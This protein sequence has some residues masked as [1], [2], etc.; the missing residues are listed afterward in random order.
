MKLSNL[1]NIK[2]KSIKIDNADRSYADY[3]YNLPDDKPKKQVWAVVGTVAAAI[4]IVLAVSLWA[5]IGRGVRGTDA[6]TPI[7]PADENV[8]VTEE[9]QAQFE[10]MFGKYS[11]HS[12][13]SFERGVLPSKEAL[14]EFLDHEQ[15]P[16]LS[17]FKLTAEEFNAFVFDWFGTEPGYEVNIEYDL[18]K[19]ITVDYFPP[20]LL[21]F[22]RSF[23]DDGTKIVTLTYGDIDNWVVTLS[24]V[25]ISDFE[26]DYFIENTTLN[27][28]F[29]H[30]TDKENMRVS[31]YKVSG[32]LATQI[33]D[34]KRYLKH[35]ETNCK[36]IPDYRVYDGTLRYD[37]M[38]DG[39]MPHT[40]RYDAHTCQLTQDEQS[41]FK[42]LFEKCETDENFVETK[43]L[44]YI[45]SATEVTVTVPEGHKEYKSGTYTIKGDDAKALI[46]ALET[47]SYTGLN[48]LEAAGMI[49][50]KINERTYYLYI[51]DDKIHIENACGGI[52][53]DPD[54]EIIKIMEKYIEKSEI[55]DGTI[56]ETGR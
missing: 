8:E 34:A 38:L 49:E 12:F 23:V 56:I 4:L 51:G 32:E 5:I 21:S 30:K 1:K 14:L 7:I 13:P 18:G 41:R 25:P 39:V 36:C 42:E 9:M 47:K 10:A 50:L 45:P 54:D 48:G 44:E 11:L 15:S 24:Y 29:L 33:L 6:D 37:F 26:P 35:S 28:I 16:Y 46:T 55:P 31:V 27:T 2:P 40:T 19:V 22:T 53:L 20:K 3:I 52:S 17:D 43:E